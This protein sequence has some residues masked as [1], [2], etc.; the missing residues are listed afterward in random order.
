[1]EVHTTLFSACFQWSNVDCGLLFQKMQNLLIK[2]DYKLDLHR[3][4]LL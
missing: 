4:K 2:T 3:V 1:M